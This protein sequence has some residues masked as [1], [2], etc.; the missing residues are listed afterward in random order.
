MKNKNTN[1]SHTPISDGD[2]RPDQNI[3]GKTKKDPG[4]P[5]NE[6]NKK[7]L[8]QERGADTNTLEDFKDAKL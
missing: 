1:E 4:A 2:T 6:E 5:R 8:T 3:D 7:P